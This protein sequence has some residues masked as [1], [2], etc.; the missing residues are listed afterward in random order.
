RLDP[1]PRSLIVTPAIHRALGFAPTEATLH[2]VDRFHLYA[3]STSAQVA[4]QYPDLIVERSALLRTLADRAQAAGAEVN[5]GWQF[6]GFDVQR[7]QT[8]VA[9]RRRS[10]DCEMRVVAQQVIGAD[11]ASSPVA[12]AIGSRAPKRVTN[13]Q[14][15]VVL[16]AGSDPFASGVWFLPKETPYFYWLVPESATTAVVGLA[17][18]D[19][20]QARPR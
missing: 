9:L 6:L 19:S 11:G 18:H 2:H 14:A 16:P 20:S 5:F 1:Q 12:R 7:K 13:L 3:G 17:L 4:L 8:A 10:A 15:R